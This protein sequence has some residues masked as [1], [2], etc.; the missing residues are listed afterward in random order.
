MLSRWLIYFKERVTIRLIF[1]VVTFCYIVF[2]YQA[3]IGKK[4]FYSL[5]LI[6]MFFTYFLFLLFWC[7]TDEFKDAEVDKQF[8]PDRS[9]PSGKVKIL[10]LK[11]LLILNI[12]LLLA[13][14]ILWRKTFPT[15]IITFA[16]VLLMA[17]WFFMEKL[18]AN[19]RI[20]AMVSHSPAMLLFF[21]N[22]MAFYS[23]YYRQ[24]LLTLDNFLLAFWVSV[25]AGVWEYSRK[26]WAPS[27]ELEGYQ[28]Y[29][30]M[31]GYKF[32]TLIS[33]I[34]AVAHYGLLLYLYEKLNLSIAILVLFGILA[35]AFLFFSFQF[36]KS[37]DKNAKSFRFVGTLYAIFSPVVITIDL[38]ISRI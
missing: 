17:K 5:D 4:Y 22:I 31:L 3:L 21:F 29:S 16:F 18:I 30:Q 34:L 32:S 10:D 7:I 9:V 27:E 33:I 23:S 14:N 24:P 15:F 28:T 8:F 6:P 12:I 11:I 25:S 26:T 19:N 13:I 20:L 38:V 1:S 36:I 35:L 37:P 2:A